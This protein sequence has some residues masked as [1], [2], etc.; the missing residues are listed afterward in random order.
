MFFLCES[1]IIF[2]VYVWG[3]LLLMLANY[4]TKYIPKHMLFNSRCVCINAL[5]S[6]RKFFKL[7]LVYLLI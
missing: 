1:I 4:M 5:I 3:F 7:L 2:D 6:T